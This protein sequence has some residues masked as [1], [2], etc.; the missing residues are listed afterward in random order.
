MVSRNVGK[1]CIRTKYVLLSSGTQI[2]RGGGSFQNVSCESPGSSSDIC[3]EG[4]TGIDHLYMKNVFFK[5][6]EATVRNRVEERDAL[7]PAVATL[8]EASPQ[9]Y[10]ALKGVLTTAPDQQMTFLSG[11][12]AG[13]R[14]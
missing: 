7:F 10:K 11:W 6:I 2:A 13:S 9:E 3:R 4:L 8:L 5:F 12:F 1:I 14:R